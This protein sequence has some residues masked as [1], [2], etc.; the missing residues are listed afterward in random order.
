MTTPVTFN[1]TTTFIS[2]I[3]A[4]L[5]WA[6]PDVTAGLADGPAAK[7]AI[8]Q[9]IVTTVANYEAQNTA[10]NLDT[11]EAEFAQQRQQWQQSYSAQQA[12]S[13]TDGNANIQ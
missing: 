6:Y 7:A 3:V 1:V 4:A 9:F 8:K 5:R 12:Q 10:G 2:R 11:L 13:T